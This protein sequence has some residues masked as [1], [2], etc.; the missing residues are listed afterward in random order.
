MKQKG[1]HLPSQEEILGQSQKL[2]GETVGKFVQVIIRVLDTIDMDEIR[3]SLS[4]LNIQELSDFIRQLQGMSQKEG[5]KDFQ[6]NISLIAREMLTQR[7][8]EFIFTDFAFSFQGCKIHPTI[9]IPEKDPSPYNRD[10]RG[11]IEI[12]VNYFQKKGSCLFF[13]DIAT[14]NGIFERASEKFLEKGLVLGR[15]PDEFYIGKQTLG[16]S[17]CDFVLI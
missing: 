3:K 12:C 10:N 2:S 13:N 15:Y 4:G 17:I 7:L 6:K 16:S 11:G 5:S 14:V 9:H 8:D 1:L